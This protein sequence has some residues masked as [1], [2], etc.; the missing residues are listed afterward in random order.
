MVCLKGD[1]CTF[2]H[3]TE[4]VPGHRY[5]KPKARQKKKSRPRSG[6]I[7]CGQVGSFIAATAIA[8]GAVQV[9]EGLQAPVPEYQTDGPARSWIGLAEPEA[10]IGS[11][12]CWGSCESRNTIQDVQ[13][14]VSP[15]PLSEES[16]SSFNDPQ[17]YKYN[18]E[19]VTTIAS[20]HEPTTDQEQEQGADTDIIN[21]EEDYGFSFEERHHFGKIQS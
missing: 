9:T 13:S 5:V 7:F 16:P 4:P 6:Q 1:A 21:T 18:F 2:L 8:A 10:S 12:R 17:F 15:L 19:A 14:C 11:T 20:S 3:P